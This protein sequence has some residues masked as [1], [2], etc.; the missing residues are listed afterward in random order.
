M[1]QTQ[2]VRFETCM[3]VGVGGRCAASGVDRDIYGPNTATARGPKR[4]RG[5]QNRHI[6]VPARMGPRR[7]RARFGTWGF[8]NLHINVTEVAP[9]ISIS[10]SLAAHQQ[11]GFQ[12]G[13]FRPPSHLFVNHDM[14]FPDPIVM[15][16]A[17]N[18]ATLAHYMPIS[19]LLEAH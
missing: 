9:Y 2:M 16:C 13:L 11:A 6:G 7:Q 8:Q 10:P 14:L 4:R 5:V 18:V 15:F 3:C 17:I 1:R 12:K 19:A